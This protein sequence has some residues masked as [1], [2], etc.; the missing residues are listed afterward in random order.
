MSSGPAT[1]TATGLPQ[2]PPKDTEVLDFEIVEE[3]WNEY[4]LADET[5]L[6]ARII[7]TRV[8]RPR[9]GPTG[10]FGF[11]F[12]SFFRVTAPREKRGEQMQIPAREEW[13]ALPKEPVRIT[14]TNEPWNRY[15]IPETG[16]VIQ[17][18]LVVSEVFRV[19]DRFDQFGEPFYMV[20]SGPLIEPA[21]KGSLRIGLQR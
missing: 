4:E 6:R 20:T 16:D 7:L 15:R 18:K 10:Q 21:T 9:F 3:R 2:P 13:A 14:T 12:E 19:K 17:L 1:P 5:K 11:S 8:M